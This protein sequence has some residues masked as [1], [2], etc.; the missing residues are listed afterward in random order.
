VIEG[1]DPGEKYYTG[2]YTVDEKSTAPW[3][4]P[5]KASTSAPALLV[6]SLWDI[7]HM[8]WKHHVEQ[9]LKAH[10]LFHRDATT[11]SKTAKSSSWTS[12]PAA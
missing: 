9:A 7:E 3:R 1:K 8:E 10:V 11:W 2:D 6:P 12:S 5:K 4:S